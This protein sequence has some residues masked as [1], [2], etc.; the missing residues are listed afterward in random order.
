MST[1]RYV[2]DALAHPRRA[3]IHDAVRRHGVLNF[4]ALGRLLGCPAGTLSH[5]LDVLRIHG[6]VAESCQD[7][8][9]LVHDPGLNA[10]EAHR[11]FVLRQPGLAAV[12]GIIAQAP[13]FQRDLFEALPDVPRSTVQHRVARLVREGLVKAH[14]QGRLMRYEAARHGAPAHG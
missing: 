8:L 14:A 10:V 5:H 13:H 1:G 12:Y 4:N 3:G 9:R 6:L 11:R 2:E 7:R